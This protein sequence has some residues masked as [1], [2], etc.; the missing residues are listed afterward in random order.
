[1]NIIEAVKNI[2]ARPFRRKN[3]DRWI[4]CIGRMDG[5]HLEYD[6]NCQIVTLYAEDI[7]AEDWELGAR[8]TPTCHEIWME[9]PQ[10]KEA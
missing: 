9:A 7:E 8:S 10:N 2:A 4:V 3:T 1:M 5:I 6:D